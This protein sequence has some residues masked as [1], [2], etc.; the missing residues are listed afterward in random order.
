M[1]EPI[2]RPCPYCGGMAY[3]AMNFGSSYITCK[4]R[5]KCIMK[6]DTWLESNLP[7]KAQIKVWNMRA[8]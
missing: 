3:V 2:L 7:L 5:R 1:S 4:H 8:N 6:P